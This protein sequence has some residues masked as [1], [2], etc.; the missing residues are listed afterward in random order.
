[1]AKIYRRNA[2]GRMAQVY[3]QTSVFWLFAGVMVWL[4][5]GC[6]GLVGVMLGRLSI[7]VRSIAIIC[8]IAVMVGGL[9]V[10]VPVIAMLQAIKRSIENQSEP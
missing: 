6:I 3:Y 5:A 2:K 7:H 8:M 10:F 9:L 1:M 4:V